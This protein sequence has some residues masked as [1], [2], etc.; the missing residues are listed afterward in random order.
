VLIDRDNF[1][2][3][4]LA[5]IPGLFWF[6][7]WYYCNRARW[8][9]KEQMPLLLLMSVLTTAYGG[10]PFD[11]VLLLVPVI[12]I[13]ARLPGADRPPRV[14]A[15]A[16]HLG[17]GLVAVVQVARGVEYF[18]FIWMCPA[19]L[20]AYVGLRYWLAKPQAVVAGS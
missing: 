12:Q 8:D 5:M 17:I 14:A 15:V 11:L 3:Q 1:R 20:A 2:L 7:P 4:F 13:A 16:V 18:W 9:W 19:V 10:W 6:A